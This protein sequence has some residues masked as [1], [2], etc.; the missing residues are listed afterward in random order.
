MTVAHILVLASV[1]L[2]CA[3]SALAED[4]V[5]RRF[6][7]EI[8]FEVR[9]TPDWYHA[10]LLAYPDLRAGPDG[11]T[12]IAPDGSEIAAAGPTGRQPAAILDDPTLGDQ[13]AQV[14]PLTPSLEERQTPFHDPGRIRKQNFF[15]ALYH[16][17][18]EA[19]RAELVTVPAGALGA[20][21]FH[22][23]GRQG[24]AC[25][26]QGA[27]AQLEQDPVG[28]GP[29]FDEVGGGFNWRRIAGT[30]RLSPHSYGMAIDINPQLGQ[31][32]KWTGAAEGRVGSYENQI[33]WRLIEAMED[34]GF[35][36]G[37]KWHHFDGMHFEYRP[38]L[39]IFSRMRGDIS[40]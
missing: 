29:F 8:Q 39:I 23:T 20:A 18:A 40:E 3:G 38:E 6:T 31:Y 32:W 28:L 34:H 27:L 7:D 19:V 33:P 11:Q 26:L 36:W 16:D 1:L 21:R 5:P 15:N 12:L 14:Y 25:Q 22:V 35:I 24:V 10:V 2:P 13:F 37:G 30:D 17:N 9:E 4:C